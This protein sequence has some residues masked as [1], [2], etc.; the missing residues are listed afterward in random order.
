MLD[1]T[2][3]LIIGMAATL[4]ACITDPTTEDTRVD[5]DL[6]A[7]FETDAGVDG[8]C[9]SPTRLDLSLDRSTISTEL[10]TSNTITVSLTGAD[11]FGGTAT[12]S[13]TILD[14]QGNPLPGWTITLGASTLAVPQNG[15]ATTTATVRIPSENRG[16]VG[17][18]RIAVASGAQ[19]GTFAAQST[20]TALNQITFPIAIVNNQCV[21]PAP[22]PN[23]VTAR[24]GTKLRWL[25]NPSNTTYLVVHIDSNPYGVFHQSTSPGSAPGQI[26]EQTL[27]G[28]PSTSF[29]W[30]CHSPGPLA[31]NYIQP[32]N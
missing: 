26:Y 22:S 7:T 21:Y 31:N 6:G 30:Y 13:A 5:I 10:S 14:P 9:Q 25:N 16:L 27:S 4:T 20:L 8:G 32:V 19:T 1:L 24:I 18:A 15:T 11:G 12:L 2:R 17:I 28:T 29:R 3:F 23:T